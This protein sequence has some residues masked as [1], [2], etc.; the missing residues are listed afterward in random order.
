MNHLK[1]YHL[2]ESK[3][4]KVIEFDILNGDGDVVGDVSGIIHYDPQYLK[5]WMYKESIDVETSEKVLNEVTFP[6][7]ILKNMNVNDSERNK[8]YGRDGMSTFLE[9]SSDASCILLI[10]DV[11]EHNEFDLTKWYEGYGFEEIG[12]AGGNPLMLLKL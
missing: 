6:V 4:P 11:L 1:E 2:F 8:G 3:S 10:S 5:N 7:S 12:K 9:E